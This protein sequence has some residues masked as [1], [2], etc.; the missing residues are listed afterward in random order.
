MG[1]LDIGYLVL[2][3]LCPISAASNLQR[4]IYLFVAG[5]KEASEDCR[6]GRNMLVFWRHKNLTAHP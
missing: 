5:P 6:R 1:D 3:E 2:F 4:P